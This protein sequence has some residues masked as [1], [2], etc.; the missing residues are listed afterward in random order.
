MGLRGEKVPRFRD[1]NSRKQP[2]ALPSERG[3]GYIRAV[4]EARPGV[5]PLPYRQAGRVSSDARRELFRRQSV[6][7]QQRC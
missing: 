1:G 3:E 2:G 4:E 5:Q 7:L 6:F